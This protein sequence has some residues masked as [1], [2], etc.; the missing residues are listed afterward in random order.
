M[1]KIL[2]LQNPTPCAL[3]PAHSCCVS[4]GRLHVLQPLLRSRHS[5][6]S[7]VYLEEA[8]FAINCAS[9]VQRMTRLRKVPVCLTQLRMETV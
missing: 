9:H 5:V 1:P 3:F 7:A 6:S 8:I 2:S 4:Q